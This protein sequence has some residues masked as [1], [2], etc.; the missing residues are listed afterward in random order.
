[1]IQ[2]KEVVLKSV[3]EFLGVWAVRGEASLSLKTKDGVTTIAFSHSLSGHPEDPLHPP[4]APTGTLPQRRRRRRGPARRERDRQRAARHQA[5]QASA[6]PVSPPLAASPAAPS[7][8]EGL[9]DVAL[10]EAASASPTL[11]STPSPEPAGEPT[12]EKE[13]GPVHIPDLV[14]SPI[15][16]QREDNILS[17]LPTLF[18]CNQIVK[19]SGNMWF[20]KRG[21]KCEKTFNCESDL[22]T[23]GHRDHYYCFQHRNQ[24]DII[25]PAPGVTSGRC[26]SQMLTYCRCKCDCLCGTE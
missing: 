10:A 16:G 11:P 12:P 6:P 5:A 19:R 3:A 14:L 26:V 22:R 8:P 15:Q 9:S 7:S 17:P 24:Y 2:K 1:M 18:L 20:G 13:R 21:P 4:P 25:C 23:H